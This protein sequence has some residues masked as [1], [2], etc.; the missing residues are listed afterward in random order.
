MRNNKAFQTIVGAFV[1]LTV[2]RLYREGWFDLLLQTP[3]DGDQVES[4]D[5]IATL[6]TAAL[7]ALQMAG[8]FAIGVVAGLLPVLQSVFD[9]AIN[10]IKPKT[11]DQTDD[12]VDVQTLNDVLTDLQNRLA[13][14]EKSDDG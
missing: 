3:D 14:L 1:V 2:F 5:L 6:I 7:S 13:A 10:L 8:L 9:G 11:N 12:V 4:V